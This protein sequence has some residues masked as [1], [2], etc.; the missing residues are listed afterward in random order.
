MKEALIEW[1][2][3]NLGGK[4]G[5]EVIVFL[6]SM[7]PILELRGG[8]IA[9]GPAFLDVPMWEAIPICIIGNFI[10]V[11][12]ILFLIT[13]I[14]DWLKHTKAFRPM[15]EKLEKK[16][17]S[18]SANIERYEFW[19]LVAFVGIPLPGTGAWT[20]SLIAALLGVKFRKAFPAVVLGVLLA[21]FI[22][23]LFSYVVL[24]GVF[25]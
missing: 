12:F 20:G 6:I 8:L 16:A 18:K 21:A 22:M 10:P 2:V 14:F 25:S 9:A 7:V 4:V 3:S 11:P 1:F 23:T 17:M 15:V 13:K 24:G 19:G 5:K